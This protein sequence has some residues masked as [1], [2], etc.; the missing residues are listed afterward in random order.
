MFDLYPACRHKNEIGSYLQYLPVRKCAGEATW[1]CAAPAN[2]RQPSS[3][4]RP[5]EAELKAQRLD[6][7]TIP[8]LINAGKTYFD[9]LAHMV[10]RDR[11]LIRTAEFG[12]D[13]IC[14]TVRK[15]LDLALI[16]AFD[17][18]SSEIFGAG[19]P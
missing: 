7:D 1:K 15:F 4:Q 13:N 18:N 10:T 2:L 11:I 16:A 5:R 19:I 8:P 14:Q 17:H 12:L 3:P 6:G 9:H